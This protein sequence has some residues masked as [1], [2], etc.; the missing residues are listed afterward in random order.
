MLPMQTQFQDALNKVTA[1][2][3]AIFSSS[4][5]SWVSSYK[6]SFH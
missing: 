5:L 1:F 3:A 4:I 6:S 2:E